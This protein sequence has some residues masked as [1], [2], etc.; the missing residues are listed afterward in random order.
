MHHAARAAPEHGLPFG[1]APTYLARILLLLLHVLSHLA[2]EPPGIQ[3]H[4][5]PF[6]G[7][8]LMVMM[9]TP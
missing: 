9:P 2:H 4:T 6:R 7:I 8:C 5:Q 3:V 1:V